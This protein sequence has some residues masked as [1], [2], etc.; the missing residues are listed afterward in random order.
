[1]TFPSKASVVSLSSLAPLTALRNSVAEINDTG[2][3]DISSEYFSD[4]NRRTK[5]SEN[6]FSDWINTA[7]VDLIG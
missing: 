5:K 6:K 3:W 4:N 2:H 1:M 7:E